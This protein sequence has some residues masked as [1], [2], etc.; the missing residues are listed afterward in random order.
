MMRGPLVY[1]LEAVDNPG[2]DLSGLVLPRESDLSAEHRVELL[3]GVT[4]L[5]GKA[6]ADGQRPI[7][8][9]AV[10]YYAWQNR[11]VHEMI[12]WILDAPKP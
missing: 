2:A 4:V 12:V 6:L 5:Q 9:T 11:G 7:T 1:C 8:L 3:G 10:P